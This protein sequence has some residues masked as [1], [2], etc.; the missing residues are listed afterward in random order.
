MYVV[1]R[2]H[3]F[4]MVDSRILCTSRY[5]V[6]GDLCVCIQDL[7]AAATPAR[8]CLMVH[9]FSD[10]AAARHAVLD[11]SCRWTS[12]T[13]T[14]LALQLPSCAVLRQSCY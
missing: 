3:I 6:V 2:Q 11:L 10:A 8:S 13:T 12:Q 5:L 7:L 4:C 9:C 14:A 1:A